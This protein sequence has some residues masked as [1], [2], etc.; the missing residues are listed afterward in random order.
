M[1]NTAGSY[2][3]V[4]A[5]TRKEASLITRLRKSG[6][7][8]LGKANMSEWGNGRSSGDGAPSGWSS[9]GWS[10]WG[11]QTY[12]VYV[13]EQ[14]PC[15]SSSGSGVAMALGLAAAT[16]GVEVRYTKQCAILTFRYLSTLTTVDCRQH[17]LPCYEEQSC[18]H[19]AYSRTGS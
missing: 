14:D 19:Q 12:G 8:I 10:A 7:I 18:R 1:N 16:V 17:H 3:L 15:G 5:K 4:D 11:G 9:N 2:C 13:T 6:A